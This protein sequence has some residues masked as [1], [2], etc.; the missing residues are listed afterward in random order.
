M[1]EQQITEAIET[2]RQ[3]GVRRGINGAI[4]KLEEI[5]AQ[6]ANLDSQIGVA[7]MA[8]A[9]HALSFLTVAEVEG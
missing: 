9:I 2:A 8:S 7:A 3:A 1:T 5:K 6:Y 4:E